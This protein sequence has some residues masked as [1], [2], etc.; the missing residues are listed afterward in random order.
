MSLACF[1]FFFIGAPLGAIIRKGGVGTPI[2]IAV[3]FFVL[4]YVISM[5]GERS[6]KEGALTPLA[7]MWM[8]T[9]IILSVGI[10]LTFMATRDSSI[11]NPEL[12]LNYIKKGLNFIFV[13]DRTPRPEIA[14]KV[15]A[16]DLAPE[17]MLDKLNDL[18]QH[19]KRYLEGD[20]RKY[21]RYNQIWRHQQDVELAEIG[22]RYD[23][24]REILKQSDIDMIRETVAEYPL[25]TLHN[26][27][28]KKDANW[29]T[30]VAAII[31]PVWL[32]LYLKAAIQKNTLRNELRN[33]L[34]ANR[35]LANELNSVL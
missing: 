21:M 18:S 26:Y 16:T 24:L 17:N 4:Y 33:I 34:E 19:C 35:N 20:F 1:I 2:I 14:C 6:A 11:F 23:N 32:Y 13:T 30:P 12:Y 8:S 27:K 29:Q 31:F 7:G 5:T 25:A 10:F 28:I 3:L 22:N 9:F 15:T